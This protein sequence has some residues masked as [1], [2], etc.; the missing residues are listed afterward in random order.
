MDVRLRLTDRPENLGASSLLFVRFGELRL[1]CCALRALLV[2]RLP[3]RLDFEREVS[4]GCP[5]HHSL[6]RRHADATPGWAAT[7]RATSSNERPIRHD[8]G[9][10][11][12][13]PRTRHGSGPGRGDESSAWHR[14][15][16]RRR[17]CAKRVEAGQ[18]KK[19]TA[20]MACA[21]SPSCA[22]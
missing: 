7:I 21:W 3:Q 15:R 11:A 16:S 14:R 19:V 18:M 8:L 12:G 6:G 17:W 13:P 20:L 1:E 10:H 4:P 9:N 2:E 22:R 5:R